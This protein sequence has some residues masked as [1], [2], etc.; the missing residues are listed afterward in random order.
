VSA[1]VK[2]DAVVL[3]A[4][5]YRE[6]SKILTAYTRQYGK[7]S[8]IVKGALR[9]KGG[10]GA[11]LE[12]M[13]LVS[14]VVYKKEGREVQTVAQCDLLRSHRRVYEDLDRME[15]GMAMIELVDMVSQA[16][17]ENTA[18]FELLTGS[19]S[20]LDAAERNHFTI[21]YHFEFH[22][23]GVLG[24]RPS[25]GGCLA[26]GA[27][28][29]FAFDVPKGGML[30]R[31][32]TSAP[33]EKVILSAEGLEA[34]RWLGRPPSLE[35]LA[36]RSLTTELRRGLEHFLWTYLRYHVT[37]MRALKSRRVFSR[38]AAKP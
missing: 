29:V 38:I 18:L 26:C 32:C 12:P 3:K 11:A 23:A 16:E 34:L 30:C 17:E 35:E 19:L 27:P 9:S 7:M 1:I 5:R 33:G 21:L 20:A 25:F 22:L 14:L 6:S 28:E 2:T 24:F 8:G 10:Y 36:G 37:G 4:I 13:A 15:V 31:K